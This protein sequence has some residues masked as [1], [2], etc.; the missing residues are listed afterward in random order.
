MCVCVRARARAYAC[1]FRRRT[2]SRWTLLAGRDASS[3]RWY[4]RHTS[5][6][7][8]RFCCERQQQH[9]STTTKAGNLRRDVACSPS[10]L[11]CSRRSGSHSVRNRHTQAQSL[12]PPAHESVR[13]LAQA[14]SFPQA[15]ARSTFS[16]PPKLDIPL[17]N[18]FLSLSL[19]PS[20]PP[21]S[22]FLSKHWD[23]VAC[24]VRSCPLQPSP[25]GEGGGG[26]D[27]G[28]GK[29]R[30]REGDERSERRR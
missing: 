18:N 8:R 30:A 4:S 13:M 11:A 24:L 16:L 7:R 1:V 28:R 15:S 19:C 29:K 22:V 9:N 6:R 17:Q 21:L 14:E 5:R 23:A 20:S 12:P 3:A 26:G 10:G 2:R 27:G 25:L